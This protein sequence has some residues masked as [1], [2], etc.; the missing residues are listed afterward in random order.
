MVAIDV[1]AG[2]VGARV[3]GYHISHLWLLP[4]HYW[5]AVQKKPLP[6]TPKGFQFSN[7][8]I[9]QPQGFPWGNFWSLF[10]VLG[11]GRGIV[12]RKGLDS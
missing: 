8:W 4:Y 7:P 11:V 12:V 9:R 3:R 5:P 1:E 10:K 6:T 2:R